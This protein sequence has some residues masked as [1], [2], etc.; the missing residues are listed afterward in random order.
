[1]VEGTRKIMKIVCSQLYET[2]L[3]LILEEMSQENFQSAKNFKLYLDTIIIN[4]PT[5]AKKY[6][7]ST[8]LDDENV[9]DIEYDGYVIPFFL[10]LEENVYFILGIVKKTSK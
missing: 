10:N 3:K 7:K 5:K 6:K 8:L 9:K 4:V 2:Q 1:M